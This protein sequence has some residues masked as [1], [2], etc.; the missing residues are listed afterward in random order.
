MVRIATA[1]VL[2]AIFLAG[3]FLLP[4]FWW[5]LFILPAVS[6]AAWE[7]GA[8]AGWQARGQYLFGGMVLA[9]S[10]GLGSAPSGG[11]TDVAV[12][13]AAALFWI[14][15]VPIWIFR[16]WRCSNV[17]AMTMAGW[18]VLAPSWLA[19]V[20]LQTWP[21]VLLTLMAIVW[22]SDT[23]ALV[24]GK[25]YGRNKFAPKV[26]P[27]K[28]WEGVAGAITAVAVYYAVM[29]LTIMPTH[30]LTVGVPGIAM[31][32]LI[33]VLGI[34]GDLFESWIKR[35]AGVKD[36]GQ[37]LPGH[38]GVLDRIDALT[39]SMPIAALGAILIS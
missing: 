7:W 36:S 30:V 22:L 26:S 13:G 16:Q 15:A 10:L 11:M 34:E 9:S 6:I 1:V 29:N 25:Q 37:L 23:F 33:T 2:L 20:R 31:F 18:M 5:S 28:T 3:L 39:S 4:N 14:V 21:T 27:G 12:F 32:L 35:T 38:G 8:L 17:V 19:L 24:V